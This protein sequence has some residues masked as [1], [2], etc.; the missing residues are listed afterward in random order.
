MIDSLIIALLVKG[1]LKI[2]EFWC[3]W[4]RNLL[5]YVFVPPCSY[6]LL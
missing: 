2:G 4:D 1:F 5:V 6:C 3:S